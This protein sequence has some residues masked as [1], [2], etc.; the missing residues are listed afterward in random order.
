MGK[1]RRNLLPLPGGESEG[2]RGGGVRNRKAG[3]P[4]PGQPAAAALPQIG[5]GVP[6]KTAT[7]DKSGYSAEQPILLARLREV[8]PKSVRL[9]ASMLYRGT[10][11]PRLAARDA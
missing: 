6:S 2:G 10:D 4:L 11:R 7:R 3:P 5:R 9:A 1:G 8:A